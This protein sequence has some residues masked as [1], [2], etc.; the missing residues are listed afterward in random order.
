MIAMAVH[1]A[2]EA[3]QEATGVW[4]SVSSF[5]KM[6]Y[7]KVFGGEVEKLMAGYNTRTVTILIGGV[8]LV[9][10]G[11]LAVVFSSKKKRIF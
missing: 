11:A 8:I 1:A 10:L 6:V 2:H 5:F 7:H 3:A 9:I 4:G